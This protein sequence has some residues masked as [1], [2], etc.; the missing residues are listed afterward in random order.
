ML[1]NEVRAREYLD[2]FGLNAL[3]SSGRENTTYLTNFPAVTYI[4]DRMASG[5]SASS[6]NFIQSYGIYTKDGERI[7]IIPISRYMFVDLEDSKEVEIYTYGKI[8][9]LRDPE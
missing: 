8:E 5:P 1:L 4:R 2:R 6:S 3:I 9:S 7:L